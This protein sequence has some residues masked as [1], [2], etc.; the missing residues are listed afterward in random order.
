M[1]V[2]SWI[3]V[4]RGPRSLPAIIGVLV[5]WSRCGRSMGGRSCYVHEKWGAIT[6]RFTDELNCMVSD[7]IS[8]VV[9]L[10]VTTMLLSHTLIGHSVVIEFAAFI[11]RSNDTRCP[12]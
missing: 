2:L 6:S 1:F 5:L 12:C 10:V 7:T 3:I 8:E 11:N 9:S 4:G